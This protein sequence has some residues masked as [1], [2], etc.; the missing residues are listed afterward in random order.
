MKSQGDVVGDSGRGEAESVQCGIEGL[1]RSDLL[2]QALAKANMVLA[3]KRV[4]ANGG[5]A[6]AD[7]L[8]IGGN[9]RET[10]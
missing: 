5:S 10:G 2:E 8:T 4:K 9:D 3:W 7:G 1:G 6:G